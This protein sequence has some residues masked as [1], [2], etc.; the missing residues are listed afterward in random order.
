MTRTQIVQNSEA[1]VDWWTRRQMTMVACLTIDPKKWRPVHHS[2]VVKAVKAMFKKLGYEGCL[3][4]VVERGVAGEWHAHIVFQE[5]LIDPEALRSNWY[6][7]HG[8]AMVR[9]AGS[10]SCKQCDDRTNCSWRRHNV[11]GCGDLEYT[12]RKMHLDRRDGGGIITE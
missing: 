10:R 2:Q 6:F 12:G 3:D 9:R 1:Y 11:R 5:E 7:K 4:G 8:K